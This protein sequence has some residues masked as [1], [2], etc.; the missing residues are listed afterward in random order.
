MFFMVGMVMAGE[1]TK[2]KLG[3]VQAP[4]GVTASWIVAGCNLKLQLKNNT[5][6]PIELDWMRSVYAPKGEAAVALVPGSSSKVSSMIAIPPMVVP[7][8][9]FAEEYVF[10]K[11]NLPTD[12]DGCLFRVPSSAVVTLSISGKWLVQPMEFEIDLD[13]L[14]ASQKAK[15]TPVATTPVS[16]YTVAS[17]DTPDSRTGWMDALWGTPP[18]VGSVCEAKDPNFP[19]TICTHTD[20]ADRQVGNI[21]ATSVTYTYWKNQLYTV[22]VQFRPEDA[23]GVERALQEAYG[24][25]PIPG[26]WRGDQVQIYAKGSTKEYFVSYTFTP[27]QEEMNKAI[28]GTP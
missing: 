8:S 26:L 9:S 5:N 12:G 10:R 3:P 27:I 28:L 16:T 2:L 13:A 25:T 21:L 6:T 18:Q 1:F 17:G 4:P 24:A 7:P 15:E 23:S 14:A 20:G 19:H 11:D 22:T